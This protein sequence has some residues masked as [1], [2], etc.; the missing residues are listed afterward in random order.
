V[1]GS[2][3]KSLQLAKELEKKAKEASK[4]KADAEAALEAAEKIKTLCEKINAEIGDVEKAIAEATA[5][6]DSKDYE[7]FKSKAE[8]AADMSKKTVS[9]KIHQILEGAQDTGRLIADVG[10]DKSQLEK[11]I[12]DTK[13]ALEKE[14]FEG[15]I[16]LAEQTWDTSQKLLHEHYGN[17]Y[18]NA[19]QMLLKAK[20]KGEEVEDLENDLKNSK[21]LIDSED[22]SGAMSALKNVLEAASDMLRTRISTDL[23]SIEDSIIA[24]EELGADIERVKEY[25][26]R[27]RKELDANRFDEAMS[28]ARRAQTDCEKTVSGK[29]HKEIRNLKDSIR[30]TKKAGADMDEA[31]SL[32]EE[33]SKALKDKEIATAIR[34]LE[35]AQGSLKDGQFK[36]VLKAIARS[37]DKFVLAKKLDVDITGA[38][39]LLNESREKLRGGYFEEALNAAD[40]AER[41]VENALSAFNRSK[42]LMEELSQMIKM[43]EDVGIDVEDY[44]KSFKEAKDAFSEKDFTLSNKK[45]S[46]GIDAIKKNTK[47]VAEKQLSEAEDIITITS[48]IKANVSEAQRLLKAAYES[49]GMLNP[50]KAHKQAIDSIESAKKAAR[51]LIEDKIS[52]LNTFLDECSKSFDVDEY[53]VQLDSVMDL[54]ESANFVEAFNKIDGMKRDLK[55]KGMRESKRLLG[56]A[57]VNIIELEDAGIDAS[58]LRLMLK[59]ADEQLQ[60][61][62]YDSAMATALEA[63]KDANSALESIA[64]KTLF[65]LKKAISEAKDEKINTTKWRTMFKEARSSIESDDFSSSYEISKKALDGIIGF[66]RDQQKILAK[67]GNCEE[68]LKEAKKNKVDASAPANV[69]EAAKKALESM[70]IEKAKDL[71]QKAEEGIENAMAMYLA[72]KL[73]LVLKSSFELAEKEGVT[74]DEAKESLGK[75]KALMKER[76]YEEALTIAKNAEKQL[77]TT[78][79]NMAEERIVEI[80]SLIADARNVGVDISRTEKLLEKAQA[81]FDEGDYE[82]SLNSVMVAGS[83]IDQIKDFSSKSAAEIRIAKERIRVAEAIGLD[84]AIQ[85][86]TLDQAID[87]LNSHKYAISFE[88]ARKASSRAEETTKNSLTRLLDSLGERIEATSQTGAETDRA[89]GLLQEARTAFEAL[90]IQDAIMFIIDC[91]QELDRADLQYDIAKNSLEVA[92]GK[93]QEAE[94]EALSIVKAKEIFAETETAMNN[95]NF[96]KAIELSISLSDEIERIKSQMDS[97]HLDLNS[98]EER[99]ERL[100]RVGLEIPLVQEL[101]KKAEKAIQSGDFVSCREICIDGERAISIELEQIINDRIELVEMFIETAIN[102]GIRDREFRDMLAVAQTSANEGLWDFA[103]E[104]IQKVRNKVTESIKGRLDESIKDIKNKIAIAKKTGVSIVSLEEILMDIEAKIDAEEFEEAFKLIVDSES[105]TLNVESL[106]KEY[107]DTKYTAESAISMAKKF[108]IPTRDCERLLAMADI[109]QEKDYASAIELAKEAAES[110]KSNLDKFNPDLSISIG[111]AELSPGESGEIS[112]EISN[113]GKALAKDLEIEIS[114]DFDITEPPDLPDVRGGQSKT[115]EIEVT[116]R[117]EGEGELSIVIKAKRFFDGKQF[118]FSASSSITVS[119]KEPTAKLSRATA[120]TKCSSCNGKIKPGFD[121]VVCD[122]C[123]SVQHL[124]CAKRTKRCGNCSAQLVF[125]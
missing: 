92:K 52:S 95:K 35:K 76:N 116:P 30:S 85:R 98:L 90:E 19:Q 27:A 54:F 64:K 31:A 43:A 110:A 3:L 50:V 46:Q 105:L 125:D 56:E 66:S 71:A 74:A 109:E 25:L 34:T 4:K 115:V 39:N 77:A 62:R 65:N 106:H 123:E 102:L 17:A 97:C 86:A 2:Y 15:A 70:D 37:R 53:K 114:G 11:L 94:S 107:I 10:G 118:E 60:M 29:L 82:T 40:E 68:L 69:L 78:F 124:A 8:K 113:N 99:I 75:A 58:D 38:I 49:I 51:T 18:S 73:I 44:Q 6:L 104:Q 47:K 21:S 93:L 14:E 89:D 122:R 63:M 22:Y 96:E 9:E 121:I 5:A 117:S 33:A 57:E 1:A 83:E 55:E 84:M 87:S 20:E 91:E 67:I 111:T 12:T 28:Y 80:Q 42:D 16:K 41:E 61:G 100:K 88:L 120:N 48:Q 32:I 23:D 24:A 26:N 81:E 101:V 7:L 13:G 45:A 36:I 108:G 59:K 79:K 112:V 72:A 119:P 103:F